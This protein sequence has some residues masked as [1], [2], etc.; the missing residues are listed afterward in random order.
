[1]FFS[2]LDQ[3]NRYF[4]FFPVVQF[5]CQVCNV[6]NKAYVFSFAFIYS[7]ARLMPREDQINC[8]RYLPS[9]SD[10]IAMGEDSLNLHVLSIE[11]IEDFMSLNYRVCN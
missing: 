4:V 2:P 9:N 10:L 3:L 8:H 5:S 11:Q 1:M 6:I 7:K